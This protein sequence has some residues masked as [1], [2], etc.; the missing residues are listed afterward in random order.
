MRR[1][2]VAAWLYNQTQID[3]KM[4]PIRKMFQII[5]IVCGQPEIPR[6]KNTQVVVFV[7]IKQA[8]AHTGKHLTRFV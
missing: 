1:E 4:H 3:A 7:Q 5:V 2:F 6:P 8:K